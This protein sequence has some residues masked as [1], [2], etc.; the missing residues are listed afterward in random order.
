MASEVSPISRDADYKEPNSDSE[1]GCCHSS[2]REKSD[3]GSAADSESTFIEILIAM[4]SGKLETYYGD[5]ST[6]FSC[7]SAGYKI[8][9]EY[10]SVVKVP[11]PYDA[12]TAL[13]DPTFGHSW[14]LAMEAELE[15]KFV[16]GFAFEYVYTIPTCR[17]V[18]K[19]MWI[20]MAKSDP[21][22]AVIHFKV[23]W[24]TCSTAT[25]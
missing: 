15:G 1:L 22:A 21:Y 5:A 23:R 24:V 9:S 3:S 19:G 17:T 12:R 2:D 25:P 16:A 20:F 7:S 18:M 10:G 11:I 4:D 8:D 13:E 6:C 14:R